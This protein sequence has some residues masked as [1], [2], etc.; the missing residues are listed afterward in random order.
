MK[1]GFVGFI[2]AVQ[3]ALV[4]TLFAQQPMTSH[5]QAVLDLLKLIKSDQQMMSM[6]EDIADAMANSNPML[7]QFRDVIVEWAKKYMTWNEI[8]P[9]IMR[10]YKETFTESEIRQI[11]AFY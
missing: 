1:K 11:I 8:L 7:G 9:H 2:L 5:D 6:T 4:G 3:L 10:L